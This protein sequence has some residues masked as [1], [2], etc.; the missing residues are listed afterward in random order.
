MYRKTKNGFGIVRLADGAIIPED[1]DN[2]DYA[3]YLAWAD[4]GNVIEEY[5]L[6]KDERKQQINVERDIALAAGVE[7]MG[8]V[9]HSD[10][11]FRADLTDMLMGYDKGL[12]TGKQSIRTKAN[13][14][15]ELDY[16]Q[17]LA[18]KLTLGQ[19]R[20]A[21]L[22]QSWTAKDAIDNETAE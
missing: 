8:H 17:I 6:S 19:T 10:D 13:N 15:V 20:Q 1:P 3:A 7:F 22:I 18:L 12:L 2:V 9:F 5:V 11:T 16:N 4:Q 14:I 21:I